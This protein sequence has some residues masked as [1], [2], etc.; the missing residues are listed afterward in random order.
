M[1]EPVTIQIFMVVIFTT[2]IFAASFILLRERHK[3]GKPMDV[4]F[5]AL[6]YGLLLGSFVAGLLYPVRMAAMSGEMD[7]GSPEFAQSYLPLFAGFIILFRTDILARIPL[8]GTAIIAYRSAMLRRGV[9]KSQAR[10][11]KLSALGGVSPG[12]LS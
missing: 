5:G 10:L 7:M 4:H 9:E 8:I 2:M 6:I 1:T 11:A 3:A 12:E